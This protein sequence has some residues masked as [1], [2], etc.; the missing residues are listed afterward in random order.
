MDLFLREV[1]PHDSRRVACV[2]VSVTWIAWVLAG[3]LSV[4]VGLLVY[5]LSGFMRSM[6]DWFGW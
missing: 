2:E 6:R 1:A 3:S 4:V 5:I